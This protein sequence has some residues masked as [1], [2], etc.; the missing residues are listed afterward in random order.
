[1]RQAV[2]TQQTQHHGITRMR[3]GVAHAGAHHKPADGR[4]RLA[5]VRAEPFEALELDLAVLWAR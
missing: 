2:S 4:P 1:V 5:W 3:R